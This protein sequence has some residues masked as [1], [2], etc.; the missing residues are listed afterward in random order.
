MRFWGRIARVTAMSLLAALIEVNI[1][2]SGA[3]PPVAAQGQR[4]ALDIVQWG[5]A[6]FPYPEFR[7]SIRESADSTA[8]SWLDCC[9]VVSYKRWTAFGSL[10]ISQVAAYI[11]PQWIT[12]TLSGYAE[13]RV[14]RKCITVNHVYLEAMGLFEGQPYQMK[15]W[16]WSDQKSLAE[17]FAAFPDNKDDLVKLTSA[18]K[19]KARLSVIFGEAVSCAD[20]EI[21]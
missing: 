17:V 7:L 3:Q 10:P 4:P 15:Y 21:F 9:S 5:E 16:L 13:S 1:L 2:L 8:G 18:E 20:L 12:V 11:T 14:T 19:I 6:F